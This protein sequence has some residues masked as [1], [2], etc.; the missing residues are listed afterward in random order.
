MS[1]VRFMQL[2]IETARTGIARG[3][4]PFGACVVRDGD[5]LSCEHNVVLATTDITA[6]A[7]VH[8]L[9]QACAAAG[10]IDLSGCTVYSTC[11]PCPMCFSACHWAR[12]SRLVFGARIEDAARAGFHE[13]PVSSE[14]LRSLG[15]TRVEVVPG[16]LRDECV[17]LF[18]S[19]ARQPGR[20][21]Y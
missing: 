6:H 9:R 2:A 17:A 7:E 14:T 1:D 11:E 4:S 20:R 12:V 15:G 13:M 21:A 5:V 18:A 16:V 8:A 19:W 3:Q 10:T